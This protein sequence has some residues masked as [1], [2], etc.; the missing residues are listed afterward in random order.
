MWVCVTKVDFRPIFII[1]DQKSVGFVIIYGTVP[2]AA[3]SGSAGIRMLIA[4]FSMLGGRYQFFKE[5]WKEITLTE[6][7]AQFQ[8]KSGA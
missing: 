3:R 2:N 1:E 5:R 6:V 7:V 4:R 8:Q